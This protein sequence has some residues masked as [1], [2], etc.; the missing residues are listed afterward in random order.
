MDQASSNEEK[1]LGVEN[2]VGLS[3]LLITKLFVINHRLFL[4]VIYH[5]RFCYCTVVMYAKT[6]RAAVMEKGVAGSNPARFNFKI[7]FFFVSN[8]KAGGYLIKKYK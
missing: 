6:F 4:I 3:L 5:K 8:L 7:N 2:L 1:K